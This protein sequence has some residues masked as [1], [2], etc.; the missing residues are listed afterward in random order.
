MP[1]IDREIAEHMSLIK[2]RFKSV[3][4]KLH[5]MRSKWSLKVTEEIDK[6][7]KAGFIKLSE[8][9]DWVANVVPV[10]KKDGKIRV[11]VDFRDLNK[12]SPKDDF[13]LPHIDILVD[14]TANH[15]L[16]S[17]MDGYAVMPFGLI[18]AGV[19]Y[20]KT[21]TT[22]LNYMMHKE[23]EVYIDDM[24]V[25]S[26]E[27]SGHLEALRKLFQRL[28]KYNMRLNPQKCAFGVTSGKLLGHI[29]SHRGIEVDPSKIK[30]IIGMPHPETEKEIRGFLGRVQYISR[31]IAKLTMICEPIF[32]KLKVGEYVMWDDYCQAEFDKVKE[33]L[34]SPPVL[35]P[36]VAG[37]PLSRY[38][39][40][41][42]TTMGAIALYLGVKKL[43]VHGDLSLVINQVGGSWKIRSQSLAS[44][45]TTIEEL[46]KYFEDIRY[47]Y[48]AREENQFAYALS[49]LAALINIPDHIDSM[50]ICVERISSPAY[51]NVINDTEEGETEPWY[52]AILK[53]KEIGE[54]PLDLD[55]PGKR[56]LQILSAQFIK[57]DDGQLYKK[58]AQGVLSQ[59]IDKP[60]AEKVMEE[61]HNG[62]CGPH[63]NAHKLVRK[64]TRLGYYWTMMERDCCKYV[65]HCHNYQIVAN[66]QH[67]APSMLY[68]MTSPWP[69]LTWGIDIIGKVHPS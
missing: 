16:L 29:V 57:T 4:Q 38:L 36:P 47:V 43:L 67:V 21:T 54:Y 12:A 7:L 26:K 8:Y 1:G 17:F 22:L 64:N 45:Q 2:P 30:D 59:Y 44:Y 58:T 60:T 61:V 69:F 3:K 20:Q 39:T 25:K 65:R 42:D 14:N 10:P 46:E 24:I 63:M 6:Q 15:A 51:L 62:E 35:S 56:A 68:T 48:L 11:C 5:R 34:S 18:N 50:P 33:I 41:T 28:R 32:K 55:T 13:P 27:R 23:V 66:V 19:T 37:L 9:S 53:F 40:V 31:F 52:T 49:K